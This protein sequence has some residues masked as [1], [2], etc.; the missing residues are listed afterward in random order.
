[1]ASGSA[2]AVTAPDEALAAISGRFRRYAED[3]LRRTRA[4]DR[5]AATG[6]DLLLRLADELDPSNGRL[7]AAIDL[8]AAYP[9]EALLPEPPPSRGLERLVGWTRTLRDVLVFV[10]ILITWWMLHEALGAY[11]DAGSQA[12]FL[13]GWQAGSFD[14]DHIRRGVQ[15]FTPLSQTAWWVVLAVLVMIAVAVAVN[16]GENR[17]ERPRY[18]AERAQIAQDLALAGHLI[19][20]NADIDVS[21]RELRAYVQAMESSVG[22]LVDR[23]AGTAEEVRAAL[24][25]TGGKRIEEA[26]QRWIDKASVLE[27]SLTALR[28][29]AETIDAFRSLQADI[30]AGQRELRAELAALLKAVEDATLATADHADV[31]RHYQEA[32]SKAMADT[33]LRLSDAV[34]DLGDFVGESRTFVDYLR[35]RDDGAPR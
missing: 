24:E 23:L 1:M 15:D 5:P 20:G 34:R 27:D 11:G 12:S 13:L 7:P 32:G 6:P 26:I 31:T 10:P 18:E 29:P 28:V 3:A 19:T 33:A 9:A 21:Y 17:L 2:L 8:A 16:A 25:S 22:A 4:A 30:A 14:P 35:R